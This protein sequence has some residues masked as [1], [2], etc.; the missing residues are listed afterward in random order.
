MA[1]QLLLQTI[2]PMINEKDRIKWV[3]KSNG[4]YLV[5]SFYNLSN[6]FHIPFSPIN[7]DD[8][9]L[10]VVWKTKVPFKNKGF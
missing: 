6:N 5:S 1:L 8:K 3:I 10:V 7:R 4:G 9:A 2:L